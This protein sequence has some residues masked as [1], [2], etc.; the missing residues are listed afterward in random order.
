MEPTLDTQI[1]LSLVEHVSLSRLA[2]L[3]Q[4]SKE[5][6]SIL[7]SREVL[8]M[9]K[10]RHC[11]YDATSFSQLYNS[12][13]KVDDLVEAIKDDDVELV[14]LILKY[15]VYGTMLP[16]MLLSDLLSLAAT[17]L[18]TK[19]F[20]AVCPMM[21]NEV[22][23]ICR[24]DETFE[25]LD[26]YLQSV[27]KCVLKSN[28]AAIYRSFF[29]MLESCDSGL[30]G[31]F[32]ESIRGPDNLG[33]VMYY[34]YSHV[35]MNG[36][37]CTKYSAYN[38]I[39]EYFDEEPSSDMLSAYFNTS[40]SIDFLAWMLENGGYSAWA[41]LD[42]TNNDFHER[43]LKGELTLHRARQ[44]EELENQFAV[45]SSLKSTKEFTP[46]IIL[47]NGCRNSYVQKRNY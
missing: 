14:L 37:T 16:R 36:E 15:R 40:L 13:N 29:S 34:S 23:A 33:Y 45:T 6:T 25:Y 19:I 43:Y 27:T 32:Y 42:F 5:M 22:N 24:V 30:E 17:L 1:L 2:L 21:K 9:L 3:S 7:N 46:V 39:R 47:D 4:T 41:L 18:S 31:L 11:Q 35:L 12:Y 38:V 8:G 44:L 10:G 28:D 20:V 26:R